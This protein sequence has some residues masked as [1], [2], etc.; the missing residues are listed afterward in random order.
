M[1]PSDGRGKKNWYVH[2]GANLL[3]P[4]SWFAMKPFMSN[5]CKPI[6]SGLPP[7]LSTLSVKEML[8]KSCDTCIKREV[9]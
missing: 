5:F 7:S 6:S 1:V 2:G 4:A 8:N 9:K 3:Q